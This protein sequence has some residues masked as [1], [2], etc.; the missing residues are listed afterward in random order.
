[1]NVFTYVYILHSRLGQL[2]LGSDSVVIEVAKAIFDALSRLSSSRAS[3][4]AVEWSKKVWCIYVHT[5]RDYGS[6]VLSNEI[7]RSS[8]TVPRRCFAPMHRL[9]T[10]QLILLILLLVHRAL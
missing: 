7:Y 4:D 1:M 8:A 9:P 6:K 2:M 3:G 10:V 5:Y